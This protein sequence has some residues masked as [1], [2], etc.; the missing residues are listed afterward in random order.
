[1]TDVEL[2]YGLEVIKDG[3]FFNCKQLS[4]VTIPSSVITIRTDAFA[5]CTALSSMTLPFTVSTLWTAFTGCTNLTL[6]F[7]GRT[8]DDI[9]AVAI[10]DKRYWGLN[11][12]QCVPGL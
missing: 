11:K 7:E 3:T 2:P 1:M 8:S 6:T 10:E 12:S 4:S 5:D 9:D